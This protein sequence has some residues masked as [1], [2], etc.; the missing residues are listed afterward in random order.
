MS[1]NNNSEHE[2]K[3]NELLEAQGSSETQHHVD[4][5]QILSNTWRT[6]RMLTFT[7]CAVAITAALFVASGCNVTTAAERDEI[8]RKE[9]ERIEGRARN[10]RRVVERAIWTAEAVGT[11]LESGQK[12]TAADVESI[13]R[14][15]VNHP[16]FRW[17]MTFTHPAF[18]GINLRD[19]SDSDTMI[20]EELRKLRDA[21]E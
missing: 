4:T 19:L 5:K 12:V 13:A 17:D 9:V 2:N 15:I 16:Q 6:N 11:Q 14:R 7:A 3:L 18:T 10:L 1:G 21:G 20:G 8:V